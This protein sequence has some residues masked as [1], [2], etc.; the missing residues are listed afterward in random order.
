M[1]DIFGDEPVAVEDP[2]VVAGGDDMFDAEILKSQEVEAVDPAAE[3]LAQQQD[4]L[5]DLENEL[6][7][8]VVQNGVENHEGGDF[9]NGGMEMVT[10]TN[11]EIP[12]MEP[13]EPLEEVMDPSQAYAAIAAA[14]ARLEQLKLEPE[15]IRVWREENNRRLAEKDELA[16]KEKEELLAQAKKE[17]EDWD[18]NRAEQLAKTKE[19][20]R[21]ENEII[22]KNLEQSSIGYTTESAEEEFVKDRDNVVP[23]S[24][25]ERVTKLCDFNP[26]ATR[27]GKDLSRM[28]QCLLFLK[29]NPRPITNSL[30]TQ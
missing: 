19:N 12:Q 11:G 16:E 28:R 3:F 25:W 22:V 18:R 9:L 23:G 24:E 15:K 8:E 26:K 13:E 29:Q 14:D 21:L 20:N 4:D 6:G 7:A 27:G 10:D 5:Q 1:A 2:V 30:P 17:L